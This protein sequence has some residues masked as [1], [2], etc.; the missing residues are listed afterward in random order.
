MFLLT[1]LMIID[2]KYV[3]PALTWGL[4]AHDC[5]KPQFDE[6]PG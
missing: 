2:I 5:G 4:T 6:A 3:K 1:Y